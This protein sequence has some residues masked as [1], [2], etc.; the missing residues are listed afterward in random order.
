MAS[1]DGYTSDPRFIHR[2]DR[3]ADVRA[4]ADRLAGARDE[5]R[6]RP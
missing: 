1:W 3:L 6:P 2:P 5:M 4:A